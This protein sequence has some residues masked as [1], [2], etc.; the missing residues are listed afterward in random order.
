MQQYHHYQSLRQLLLSSPTQNIPNFGEMLTFLGQ[1][2]VKYMT[3]LLYSAV[4]MVCIKIATGSVTVCLCFETHANRNSSLCTELSQ[5]CWS[6][7]K[8]FAGEIW[9]TLTR[10]GPNI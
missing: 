9:T 5:D 4:H 10:S 7:I 1:V 8:G 6:G 2:F 3:I